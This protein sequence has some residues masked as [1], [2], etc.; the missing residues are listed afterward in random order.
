MILF[1]RNIEAPE[2]VRE[3]TAAFRRA[4]G[5]ENAPVLV[6]QEGGRV[7]RLKPP[8]WPV[9]PAPKLYGD[10]F[11]TRTRTRRCGRRGSVPV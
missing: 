4:V 5:R 8:H 10:L 6:D 2:Q 3:L 11:L 7:Q 1:A 9:Y